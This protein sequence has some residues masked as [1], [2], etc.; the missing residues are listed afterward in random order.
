VPTFYFTNRASDVIPDDEGVDYPDEQAA[1]AALVR[2][3]RD[4]AAADVL[5]GKFD[6]THSV[7]LT[8]ETGA[9][10]ASLTFGDAAGCG[11]P[12]LRKV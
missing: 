5:L 9:L 3:T 12:F 7:E 11:T 1:F 4:L 2:S 8:N 6:P 10:V